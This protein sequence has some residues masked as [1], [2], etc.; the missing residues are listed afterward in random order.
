MAK[1]NIDIGT[2]GN[3]ST[4]DSLRSAFAKVNATFDDIY[5]AIGDPSTGLYTTA[6]TNG[7]VKLQPNGV[8]VVEIDQL[9]INS[10]AITSTTTNTTVSIT[11]NGTG[12]VQ[13]EE[14]LFKD[15]TISS[16]DSS[17]IN[18]NDGVIIDG[19]LTVNGEFVLNDLAVG[20]LNVDNLNF[21]DNEIIKS[22]LAR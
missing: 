17:S 18:I 2:A 3:P 20:T 22:H 8:G 19:P 14:I 1:N 5:I 10:S 4:G 11:G 9:Q 15:S 21:N 7:D 6:L 12:G 16:V 13:V